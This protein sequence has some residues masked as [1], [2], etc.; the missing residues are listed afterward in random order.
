MCIMI[1]LYTQITESTKRV[2]QFYHNKTLVL[3]GLRFC[4]FV[5]MSLLLF[6][7][8]QTYGQTLITI[9]TGTGNPSVGT[10]PGT[11]AE[12][13]SPYGVNVGSGSGGK[14]VQMIYTAAMI[15]TAMTNAGYAPGASFVSTIGYNITGIVT[16]TFVNQNYT[17]KMAN[18][19]Q[20][21]LS[22]GYYTGAMTTVYGAANTTFAATGWFSLN[23]GTPFLWDGTSNLCIEV[24]YNYTGVGFITTYGGCQYT[25]V[26]GNNHMGFAGGATASCATA[27]PGTGSQ[28]NRLC[29]VRL[30]VASATPCSGAPATATASTSTVC[31][32]SSA[33]VSLSG[34]AGAAGYTYLWKQSSASTYPGSFSNAA[35]TNNGATYTTTASLPFNPTYYVC[36]VTCSNS[37]L[38]TPSNAGNVSLNTFLNCYCTGTY[39]AANGGTRGI[40]SVGIAAP[41]SPIILNT[42]TVLNG[43]A[44][45]TSYTL[46]TGASPVSNAGLI[47]NTAYVLAVKVSTQA[48]ASNN[49]GAWIDYNQNGFF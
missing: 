23:I 15:N 24:C 26:G 38:M 7:T 28:T 8:N 25:A 14:K 41:A 22:G 49:V 11:T 37:G 34:L 35:G 43:G 20:G 18:V 45:A 19:V 17:V 21:D 6:Q 2:F 3:F 44:G 30:T 31:S 12:A 40:V 46:Y 1:E 5:L 36:E 16:T 4:W 10:N 39:A 13:C 33:V 27:Y 48:T 42:S 29:N 9:G 47:I 32:G